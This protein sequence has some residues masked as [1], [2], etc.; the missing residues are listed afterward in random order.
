MAAGV[1]SVRVLARNTVTAR[2]NDRGESNRGFTY[3]GG[4]LEGWSSA[5]AS[6]KRVTAAAG[7][8]RL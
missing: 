4:M 2:R 5:W 3:K 1:V 8:G 7:V 6:G